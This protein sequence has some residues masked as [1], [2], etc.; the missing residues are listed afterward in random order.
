[1]PHKQI[2]ARIKGRAAPLTRTQSTSR[3][4]V[5]LPSAL[6]RQVE[7]YAGTSDISIS[8]AVAALVRLGLESQEARKREFFKKLRKNLANDNPKLEDQMVNE[9]R[10]LILGR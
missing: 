4:S 7:T 6:A 9:F 1:M 3:Y 10:S 2:V 5:A 8:K